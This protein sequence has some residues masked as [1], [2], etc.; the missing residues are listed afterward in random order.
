MCIRDQ[1]LSKRF[2]L[3]NDTDVNYLVACRRHA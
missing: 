3:S 2:S 1:P